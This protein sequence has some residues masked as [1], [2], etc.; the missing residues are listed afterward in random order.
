MIPF[1]VEVKNWKEDQ[2]VNK[3]SVLTKRTKKNRRS[4]QSKDLLKTRRVNIH[5]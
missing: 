4:I 5:I 1:F 3:K 2:G